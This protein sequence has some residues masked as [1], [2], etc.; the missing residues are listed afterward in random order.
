VVTGDRTVP[1]GTDRPIGTNGAFVLCPPGPFRATLEWTAGAEPGPYGCDTGR[2]RLAMAGTSEQWKGQAEEAVGDL[3]G[4]G[5][6]KSQGTADRH[7]GKAKEEVGKVEE[8]VDEVIDKAKSALH[9]K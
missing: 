2:R 9:K 3:T 4:N 1:V 8:K 6:V 5:K 7:A